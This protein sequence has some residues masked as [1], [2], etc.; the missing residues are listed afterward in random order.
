MKDRY[1]KYIQSRSFQPGNQ[2]LVLLSVPDKPFQARYF[3]P[4]IVTVKL[5]DLNYNVST[6]D[7]RKKTHLCHIKG[8]PS[9]LGTKILQ[10]Y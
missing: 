6:A 10:K 5:S 1:D 9:D 8:G 4:Y 2:I 7:R 3:G